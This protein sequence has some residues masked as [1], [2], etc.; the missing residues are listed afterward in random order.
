MFRTY[1]TFLLGSK[2][3]DEFFLNPGQYSP[4]KS[5]KTFCFQTLNPDQRISG[6][7]GKNTPIAPELDGPISDWNQT[8]GL[9]RPL[10]KRH[11]HDSYSLSRR[12]FRTASFL[13]ECWQDLSESPSP[14][15]TTCSRALANSMCRLPMHCL[16]TSGFR[17]S[18]Y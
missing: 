15:C 14:N 12:A 16:T 17:Y 2:Y 1:S 9:S 18:I 6:Q 11:R 13:K 10:F 7:D 3:C 4:V 8:R 5:G